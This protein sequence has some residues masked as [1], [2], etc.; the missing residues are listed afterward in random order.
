MWVLGAV[1]PHTDV[2]MV[3]WVLGAVTPH[4]RGGGGAGIW[5]LA[6]TTKDQEKA[7]KTEVGASPQAS[8]PTTTAVERFRSFSTHTTIPTSV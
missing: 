2:G 8:T 3:V 6:P 5:G 7:T 4:R 1:T